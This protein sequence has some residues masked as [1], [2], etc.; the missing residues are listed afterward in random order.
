MQHGVLVAAD[1]AVHREPLPSAGRIERHIVEVGA[2]VAEMVPGRVEEG[3]AHVG[4]A[5][6]LLAADRTGDVVPALVPREWGDAAVVRP[7]VLQ[8]GQL[9]RKVLLR[10]WYGAV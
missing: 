4:L 3:V 5:P 10:D 8:D 6:A 2:G 7:E 9:D 1:V